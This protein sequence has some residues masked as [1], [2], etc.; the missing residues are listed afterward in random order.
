MARF[1]P[2][3]VKEQLNVRDV[4]LDRAYEEKE[5]GNTERYEAYDKQSDTMRDRILKDM[6][7]YF[8]DYAIDEVLETLTRFGNAPCLVYD[9]NGKFAVSGDGYQP[10][11]TGDEVIDGSVTV[12][13]EGHMWKKTIREAVYHY[14]TYEEP[15]PTE[16]EKEWMD[17]ILK[18][19]GIFPKGDT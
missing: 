1:E 17:Q 18:D 5:A 2:T 19:N 13:V 14:L 8:N 3:Y 10:V 12:V 9:D 7:E 16:E 11:V 4:I 15:E 6:I